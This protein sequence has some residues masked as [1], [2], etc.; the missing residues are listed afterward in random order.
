MA[1]GGR[2]SDTR[3]GE[4][5]VPSNGKW[6][7]QRSGIK[8]HTAGMTVGE[9]FTHST[10]NRCLLS[11]FHVSSYVLRNWDTST[12][13]RFFKRYVA[14]DVY[15]SNVVLSKIG[16]SPVW[17]GSVAGH[18]PANQG[19]AG[20]IPGQG[21]CRGCRP[22]PPFRGIVATNQCFSLTSISLSLS[23]SLLAPLSK[24]K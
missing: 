23:L 6:A 10:F 2:K 3:C 14:K 13:D 17:C 20:S 16:N 18:H 8:V 1:V 5:T 22:G 24:N 12:S 7:N 4:P 11:T 9:P 19:V 15:C 21:T